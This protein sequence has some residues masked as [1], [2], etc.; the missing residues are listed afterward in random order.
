[1]GILFLK[2]RKPS[3]QSDALF[4]VGSARKKLTTDR[5]AK[6]INAKNVRENPYTRFCLKIVTQ[7][8]LNFLSDSLANTTFADGFARHR[9][10]SVK[11]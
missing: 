10:Q 3:L 11:A 7:S 9:F 5:Y 6:A 1:M 8:R 2:N 4:R